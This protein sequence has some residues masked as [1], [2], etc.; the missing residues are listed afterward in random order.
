ML[1]FTSFVDPKTGKDLRHDLG[2]LLVYVH[3]SGMSPDLC[4]GDVA[5]ID[6][7]PGKPFEAGDIVYVDFPGCSKFW[8]VRKTGESSLE[9]YKL[10]DPGLTLHDFPAVHIRGKVIGIESI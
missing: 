9:L 7:R 6:Q 3:E 8:M 2:Y 1:R 4:K 5:V 10:S